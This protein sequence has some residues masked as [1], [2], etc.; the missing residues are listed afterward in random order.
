MER[1][2]IG[3]NPI[4]LPAVFIKKDNDGNII[5]SALLNPRGDAS[6]NRNSGELNEKFSHNNYINGRFNN[7]HDMT[8]Y[9]GGNNLYVNNSSSHMVNPYNIRSS[10]NNLIE[11]DNINS[12]HSINRTHPI[13]CRDGNAC[14]YPKSNPYDAIF[15]NF[16]K[17]K[18]ISWNS[19]D[20]AQN[21]SGFVDKDDIYI[22]VPPSESWLYDKN[23]NYFRNLSPPDKFD[24][25]VMKFMYDNKF[26]NNIIEQKNDILL[27]PSIDM[28]NGL[29]ISDKSPTPAM[30]YMQ[31]PY[32]ADYTN[33]QSR[34]CSSSCSG[35]YKENMSGGGVAGITIGGILGFLIIVVAIYILFLNKPPT[36]YVSFNN[37]DNSTASYDLNDTSNDALLNGTEKSLLIPKK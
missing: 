19:K 6:E 4:I 32:V 27:I 17:E 18:V 11:A 28:L 3:K 15:I 12:I 23:N 24:S 21:L 1:N 35:S 26:N 34:T 5:Q 25:L 30:L 29:K 13:V 16:S 8:N 10:Y 22:V 20:G 37:W 9:D 2:F 7:L 33:L 31:P 14:R 36:G